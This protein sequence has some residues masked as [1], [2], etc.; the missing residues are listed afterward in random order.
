MLSPNFIQIHQGAQELR[1]KKGPSWR[2]LLHIGKIAH[3][4]IFDW[5]Y[6][7]HGCVKLPGKNW[8]WCTYHRE[9][10]YL[11]PSIFVGKCSI[12]RCLKLR[13]L[14]VETLS[15]VVFLANLSINCVYVLINIQY[16][17]ILSCF[18]G[19]SDDFEQVSLFCVNFTKSYN[20]TKTA[21][22]VIFCAAA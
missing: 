6:L 21:H 15:A 10:T 8:A 19:T 20:T 9:H 16:V 3:F 4:A 17:E 11:F 5:P 2:E 12:Y 7:L 1:L 22:F 13:L 14:A 18:L